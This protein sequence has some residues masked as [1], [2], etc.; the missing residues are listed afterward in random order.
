MGDF[1]LFLGFLSPRKN[2]SNIQFPS[3]LTLNQSNPMEST[4]FVLASRPYGLPS[5]ANFR[6]E[7]SPLRQ[8]LDNEVLLKSWYISVDPYMRGRMNVVKSYAANYEVDH[9]IIGGIVAKV[10]DSKS[11]SILVGDIVKGTL[12]W[13][14]YSIE[15]AENLKKID[16]SEISPTNF[17]G[18]LGMPGYTAYFGMI[19]ICKPA[20]GETV[21]VSGAAGAVG[22]AA[23]QLAKIKGTRVIGITGSDEKCAMLRDQFGFDEAVNYKTTKSIRKELAKICPEGVDVYF[24]N[25]GGEITEGVVANLDYHARIAL[26][27]QISQYNSTKIPAGNLMMSMLLT[28]SVMLQGFIVRNYS[29]RYGEAHQYLLKLWN[30]GKLKYTET[31]IE[32]F[33]SLPDAFLGL[34]HGV[35]KGKMLVKIGD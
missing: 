24:D 16:V 19:D 5:P 21:V 23:G 32:G 20:K 34:F 15:N 13:A 33:E 1:S 12:P 11:K 3:L 8:L 28:K 25:V 22:L 26:C 4:Q 31:I 10:I 14:T 17:L 35:N 30:E 2:N 27:G 18:I 9:P 29:E 7:K 6:I